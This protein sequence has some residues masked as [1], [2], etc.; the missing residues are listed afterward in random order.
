MDRGANRIAYD[1]MR[2]SLNSIFQE[3]GGVPM[4]DLILGSVHDPSG[5]SSLPPQL[6]GVRGRSFVLDS[7]LNKPQ[8]VPS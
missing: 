2:D 5:T 3:E 7:S 6:G 4:R 1:R 8:R